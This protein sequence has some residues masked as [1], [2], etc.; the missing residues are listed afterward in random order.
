MANTTYKHVII[1]PAVPDH[2]FPLTTQVFYGGDRPP[3]VPEHE[4]RTADI[5]VGSTTLH[6]YTEDHWTVWDPISPLELIVDGESCLASPCASN[7]LAIVDSRED[8]DKNLELARA[9][10]TLVDSDIPDILLKG[11]GRFLKISV[12]GFDSNKVTTEL[13]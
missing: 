7:G 1:T 6:L 4:Y 2:I 12:C 11:L 3:S 9:I 10:P 8:F 5:Y 13:T